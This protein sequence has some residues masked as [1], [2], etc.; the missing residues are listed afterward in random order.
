MRYFDSISEN[1]THGIIRE[2]VVEYAIHQIDHPYKDSTDYDVIIDDRPYPPVA[3]MGIA[4]SL[5]D[6]SKEYPSLKGGE[7][8]QCFNRWAELGFKIV[9]KGTH[10]GQKALRHE[11]RS[12]TDCLE[13][14]EYKENLGYDPRELFSLC[15][16]QR[17]DYTLSNY[18]GISASGKASGGKYFFELG[19]RDGFNRVGVGFKNKAAGLYLLINKTDDQHVEKVKISLT[20]RLKEPFIWPSA[21]NKVNRAFNVNLE[22]PGQYESVI[23]WLS[24]EKI[25]NK[26]QSRLRTS[27][28]AK[29]KSERP[30]LFETSSDAA[31]LEKNT[32]KL[33][34]EGLDEKPRGNPNPERS[35]PREGKGAFKRDP[36]VIAWVKQRANRLCELCEKEAPFLDRNNQPFLEV[37]HVFP[38]ADNGPDTIDN[39]VGLC[40]NCHRECHHGTDVEVLREYLSEKLKKLNR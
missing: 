11:P 28:S 8:T 18:L 6:E 27:K 13:V 29:L 25:T 16:R 35:D 32:T 9:P 3:I 1:I 20:S 19:A 30:D 38:L 26:E 24:S 39:A 14:L 15:L 2:A 4:S 34:K 10:V 23:D 36:E 5:A 37:H 22:T 40:P 31:V 12:W 17:P 33:L 7:G 21:G